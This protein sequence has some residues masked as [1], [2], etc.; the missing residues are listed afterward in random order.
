MQASA[1]P[2]ENGGNSRAHTLVSCFSRHSQGSTSSTAT[3][4]RQQR[5]RTGIMLAIVLLPMPAK[6][7]ASASEGCRRTT[8]RLCAFSW[9]TGRLKLLPRP[10]AAL[11]LTLAERRGWAY[12][13]PPAAAPHSCPPL[14][15][16]DICCARP[17]TRCLLLVAPVGGVYRGGTAAASGDREGAEPVVQHASSAADGHACLNFK[18]PFCFLAVGCAPSH[19]HGCAGR[20][21]SWACAAAGGFPRGQPGVSVLIFGPMVA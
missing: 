20:V 21:K 6:Q 1:G 4:P 12:S 8:L 18:Y 15:D 9:S 10:F 17:T 14:S 13:L 19:F 2:E 11:P 5:A 3:Q 16:L 7:A